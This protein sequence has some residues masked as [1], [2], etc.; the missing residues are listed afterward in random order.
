MSDAAARD[1]DEYIARAP[2]GARAA[3][4]ELRAII[5]SAA[6]EAEER[7]SYGMPYY[8][9]GGKLAYFSVHARH[10]GLYPAD[11]ET[12]AAVGLT[13]Y[14]AEKSTLQLPLDQPLP[15]AAIRSFIERRAAA[16]AVQPA[17]R[18]KG[19]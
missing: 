8:S 17:Q 2:A 10:I 12:A 19:K 1:V 16:L 3:L 15:A 13:S 11:R 4:A 6:P 5:R 7:I 14:F 9:L 18:R